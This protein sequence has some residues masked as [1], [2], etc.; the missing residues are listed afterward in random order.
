MFWLLCVCENVLI[1]LV[2]VL[3]VN[4]LC[5]LGWFIVILVIFL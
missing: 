2:I 3:G 4:V 1:I 5:I